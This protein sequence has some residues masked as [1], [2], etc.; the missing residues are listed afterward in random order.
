MKLTM[1]LLNAILVLALVCSVCA[2]PIKDVSV[3]SVDLSEAP[4]NNK[5]DEHLYITVTRVDDLVDDDGSLLAERV[6]AVRVQFDVLEQQL[7]CN[8]VPV[9]IGVSNIQIEAQMAANPA[10]L[11]IE[12]AEDA[13]VLE[14]SF[15]IGL[16]TVEV[17][18][19]LMDQMTTEDGLTFRR[20]LVQERITEINGLEVVQTEAGQQVLDVFDNGKLTQWGVDPLTGFMLPEPQAN[21]DQKAEEFGIMSDSQTTGCAGAF[22]AD[23]WNTQ[24]T[25]VRSLI[26]GTLCAAL[27][28]IAVAI[29]QLIVT[30]S[31]YESVS[32]EAEDQVIWQK[33]S[34]KEEDEKRPFIS[35]Q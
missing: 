5:G 32:Q 26:T 7:R 13:A 4:M 34:I 3:T 1:K 25:M 20:L 27:F 19:S 2:A 29:R 35:Q 15:D 16:A 11:S 23:W 9:Q 28:L 33:A 6:M 8:G 14:D 17:N 12:S 22:V 21:A 18:V 10:K 24:T 30:A 31:P